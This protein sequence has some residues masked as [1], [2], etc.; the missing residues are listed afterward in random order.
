MKLEGMDGPGVADRE[1]YKSAEGHLG[2]IEALFREEEKLGWMK[3]M[4]EEEA[5]KIYGSRLFVASLAV[6]QEPGKIRVVHDGSNGV[7]VN[8]RIRP[9]DQTRSP[10]AGELRAVLRAKAAMGRKMFAIAGDV[11]KAHR[12]VKVLQ[13]DWGFQA[14]RIQPGRIWLN[15]VG[16]YGITPAGYFWFRAAA[17][18]LVRLSHYLLVELLDELLLYSDDFLFLAESQR[19]VEAIGFAIFVMAVMGVPFRWGKFKGGTSLVWIGYWLDVRAFRIG[20]SKERAAWLSGW[21]RT[22]VR[23][24]KVDVQHLEAVLGRLCFAVGRWSS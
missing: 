12:R 22:R 16:T 17:G 2:A 14:C 10:G 18:I 15:C 3:E 8:H 21:L 7:H 5:K 23:E 4:D 6:V 11:S 19:Q 1:N 13:R 9:R 20:V 24:G